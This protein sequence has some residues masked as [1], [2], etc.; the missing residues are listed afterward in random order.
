M[1]TVSLASLLTV[2]TQ[3]DYE[4]RIAS[5][6]QT[7]GFPVT[8]WADGGIAKTLVSSEA[9]ANA[10]FAVQQVIIARAG[11]LTT[12]AS[13]GDDWLTLKAF[14][15]YQ[16]TR[17]AATK[18]SGRVS[19]Y[20]DA[21]NGPYSITAGLLRFADANGHRYVNTT[22]GTLSPN[23]SL[24][25]LVQAESGGE[26]YNVANN[27]ITILETGLSGVSVAK[28]TG[29]VATGT[30]PTVTVAGTF[31]PTNSS[32]MVVEILS[33][34]A[35]GVATFRYS[36]NGGASWSASQTTAATYSAG[37]AT[38]SFATGTYVLGDKYYW[39]DN[40]VAYNPGPVQSWITITG[41]DEESNER[42]VRRCQ[43]KW[44]TLGYGQNDDWFE[45]YATHGHAYADV[46]TRVVVETMAPY[47]AAAK[48]AYDAGELVVGGAPADQSMTKFVVTINTGGASGVATFDWSADNGSSWVTGVT[49]GVG[50]PL[51]VTGASLSFPSD[52]YVAGE[53]WRFTGCYGGVLVT[54]ATSS[55]GA[56]TTIVDA[57]Q[58]WF[59]TKTMAKVLVESALEETVDVTVNVTA[60]SALQGTLLTQAQSAIAQLFEDRA[61]GQPLYRAE[62]IAAVM[63]VGARNVE[64]AAPLVDLECGPRTVLVEGTTTVNLTWV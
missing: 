21:A 18:T 54:I 25:L 13:A 29:V 61:L 19:I 43:S 31:H 41:T 33:G 11:Y 32:Q 3:E 20:C 5:E 56:S 24:D 35:R 47:T 58:A 53:T 8:D 62:I 55:G 51:G 1:T 26:E 59:A 57:V 27:Q 23:S 10:T 44:S 22:S 48:Y 9:A 52:N 30:S 15:D 64:V 49:T 12:A 45:Y 17:Y 6:L 46:V 63:A 40:C 4:E 7:A 14:E 42:L 50:I 60:S 2:E 38:I 37:G 39:A 34:G 28:V 16:T 36:T